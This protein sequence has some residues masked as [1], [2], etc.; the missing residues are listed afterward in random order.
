M[1]L[2]EIEQAARKQTDMP[3]GL[4]PPDMFLFLA[5]RNI[6]T[7]FHMG[8]LTKEK[9]SQEKQK[10]MQEYAN[11][12]RWYILFYKQS[13]TIRLSEEIR[14]KI[15]K[16]TNITEIT[17]LALECIGL[18]TGDEVFLKSNIGKVKQE[19]SNEQH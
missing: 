4:T 6:Y 5:L 9:G 3:K 18:M 11:L 2:Q 17:A 15:N 10:V 14:Q 16:S 19:V 7:Y 13:E 8:K 12:Q 1:T